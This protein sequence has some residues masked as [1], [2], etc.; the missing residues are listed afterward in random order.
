[1]REVETRYREVSA[2]RL[3][4]PEPAM[5]MG[6]VILCGDCQS[7]FSYE[8]VLESCTL[9]SSRNSKTTNMLQNVV[10][11]HSSQ[12]SKRMLQSQEQR[13]KH[14]HLIINAKERRRPAMLLHKRQIR[15]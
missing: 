7:L 4:P 10:N 11:L 15:S 2:E 13:Q 5:R 6:G 8:A 3:A 12:H 9:L 14:R 1:M